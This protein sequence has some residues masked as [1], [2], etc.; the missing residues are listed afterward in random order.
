MDSSSSTLM[1]VKLRLFS[2]LEKKKTSQ[3]GGG[4]L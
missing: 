4:Q 3:A 1:A 2:F